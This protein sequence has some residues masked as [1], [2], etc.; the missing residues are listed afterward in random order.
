MASSTLNVDLYINGSLAS[1]SF[2]APAGSIDD[3]AI[4]GAAK[5]Q[6]TK[7]GHRNSYNLQLFEAATAITALTQTLL[8]IRGATGATISV[9]AWSE[10]Q[11]TGA[12]RTVTVDLQKSTSGGAYAT[13]LSATIGFTNTTVIRTAVG[14]TFSATTLVVG[15]ILRAVVTVAGAAG[16]QAKG[17]GLTLVVDEDAV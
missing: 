14:G 5:I 10:V 7:L 8:M 1:K 13:V 9:S 6:S 17:L 15:D 11:A 12:D 4:K 2:T 3:A 16:A